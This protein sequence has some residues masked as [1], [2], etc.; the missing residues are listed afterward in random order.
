MFKSCTNLAVV[1]LILAA[2]P[3]VGQQP[4]GSVEPRIHVL[5]PTPKTVVW[6]YFDGA[7]KPVLK[8]KSGETVALQTLTTADIAG[9]ADA[10]SRT[11]DP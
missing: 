2:V 1:I 10:L 3:Q 11:K 8:V 4:D 9:L 7:S 6:G 5:K